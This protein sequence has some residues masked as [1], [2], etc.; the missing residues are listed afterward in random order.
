MI[1]ETFHPCKK[2]GVL[3]FHL[4]QLIEIGFRIIAYLTGVISG[5]MS[6][7]APLPLPPHLTGTVHYQLNRPSY[8]VVIFL[9]QNYNTFV[10]NCKLQDGNL[11][12]KL[13][14]DYIQQSFQNSAF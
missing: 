5:Y 2:S 12:D 8:T 4:L 9:G 14:Q 6:L 3:D 7:F 10:L 13:Q 1:K 11:S